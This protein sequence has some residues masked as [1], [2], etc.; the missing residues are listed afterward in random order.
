VSIKVLW[1][2]IR[3]GEPYD[4]EVEA[5]GEGIEGEFC[6]GF[7]KVTDEQWAS[8]DGIVCGLDIPQEHLEKMKRCRIFVKRTVGYDNIDLEKWGRL[9][10]P[11]CNNP[12]YGTKDVADH[13][14]A[15]M[16][17][18]VKGIHFHN[19]RL[20]ADPVGNWAPALNP[21]GRRL[22]SC[23][24][25]VVGL[26]RI[27]TAT[28]LRAKA[29]GMNVV[30]YD[31]YKEEESD[32]S[33][34]VRRAGSLTGLMSQSNVVSLHTPLTEETRK[35]I[36]SGAFEA[37]QPGLILINTAR[38]AVVDLNA[39]YQAMRK[40]VVLAAGL[41]VLPREPADLEE[42]LIGAW[43]RGEDWLQDRLIL[44]PHSAFYTP[45]SLKDMRAFAARTAAR[46]LRDGQLEHC[47]NEAYLDFRR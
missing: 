46:Y 17:T 6:S 25:G 43:H 5:L 3:W 1:P 2:H 16:V 27:G 21:F 30:F 35:I 4:I 18:L 32:S 19:Q 7:E 34:G 29:F 22:S 33:L 28:A 11:V 44:T 12:E 8:C 10:V 42:P 14:I 31:P 9:G 45:E 39:L 15:L 20:L 41:D 36:G 26:G 13:A 38:G 24:F 47:V 23:T 37:A 40:E